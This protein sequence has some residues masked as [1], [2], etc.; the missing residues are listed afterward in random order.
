VCG[1][2]VHHAFGYILVSYLSEGSGTQGTR[3]VNI[4]VGVVPE[5]ILV[6]VCM[7]S[8]WSRGR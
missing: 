3:V 8:P 2:V 4:Y 5:Y 7:P 6:G 1:E